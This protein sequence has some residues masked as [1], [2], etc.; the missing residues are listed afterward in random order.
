MDSPQDSYLVTLKTRRSLRA[1]RPERPKEPALGLKLTQNTS[2]ID[3]VMT[4]QSNLKEDVVSFQF[5]VL[6]S[7][8]QNIECPKARLIFLIL[9]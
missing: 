9:S 4:A 6:H 3:P 2:N 1:L 8:D 7:R 5:C